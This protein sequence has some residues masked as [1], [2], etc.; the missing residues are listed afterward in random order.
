MYREQARIE[1]TLERLVGSELDRPEVEILLVDDGS[2]DDTVA[3]AKASADELGLSVNILMLPHQ[4]KGAAVAA[5][6]LAARGDLVAFVDADLSTTVADIVAC[7]DCLA[8]PGTD[9]VVA[10]RAH[11]SSQVMAGGSALRRVSGWCF[12]ITM[13]GLGLT[14]LR[15]TQCGLK[16]FRAE[17]RE[18]LFGGLRTTG[19][20]FDIEILARAE[21]CGMTIVELPVRWSHVP[22]SRV[23]VLRDAPPMLRDAL[24]IRWELH[25][26]PL[27]PTTT[28]TPEQDHAPSSPRE[29]APRASAE[30]GDAAGIVKPI[31]P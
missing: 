1:A 20:A 14:H 18:V 24:R 7:F 9:V 28:G 4:G 26:H 12:N 21:Q 19:F 22:A 13:R 15:D 5:G 31:G 30:T 3:V 8:S 2:D 11:P 27:T 17:V 29:P 23:R 16:G 10:T 25:R 6:V